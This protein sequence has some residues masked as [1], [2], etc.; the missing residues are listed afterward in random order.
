VET[1]T[2]ISLVLTGVLLLMGWALIWYWDDFYTRA[3]GLSAVL[4]FVFLWFA[5]V[6]NVKT[7]WETR[8]AL[9]GKEKGS[10]SVRLTRF[11]GNLKEQKRF[12]WLYAAVALLMAA[13]FLLIPLIWGGA[14]HMLLGLE[15]WEI[16][17]FAV[18][19]IVQTAQNWDEEVIENPPVAVADQPRPLPKATA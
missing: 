15:T 9:E 6:F 11:W 16:L 8:K 12:F 14:E 10:F 5:I 2:W 18:Y 3:H 13:G 7:H 17:W 4:F 19:W 1:G